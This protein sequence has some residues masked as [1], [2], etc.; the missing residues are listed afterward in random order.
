[1]HSVTFRLTQRH[2]GA[3]KCISSA[4][5]AHSKVFMHTQMFNHVQPCSMVTQSVNEHSEHVQPCSSWFNTC[6]EHS[7]ALRVHSSTFEHVQWWSHSLKGIQFGQTTKGPIDMCL[8]TRSMR[9]P[10]RL[11]LMSVGCSSTFCD[12]TSF[13]KRQMA[14]NFNIGKV[15]I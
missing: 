8:N 3:L 15:R 4:F 5:N 11:L 7:C 1:M 9:K 14:S 13:A 6:S 12:Y 2:S 10:Y